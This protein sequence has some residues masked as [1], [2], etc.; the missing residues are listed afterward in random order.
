MGGLRGIDKDGF[1]TLYDASGYEVVGLE[2][3]R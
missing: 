3:L 2:W 1:T